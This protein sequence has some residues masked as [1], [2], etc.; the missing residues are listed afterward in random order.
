MVNDQRGCLHPVLHAFDVRRSN[1]IDYVLA[2]RILRGCM[3]GRIR[4]G[5]RLFSTATCLSCQ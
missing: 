5:M 3:P 4:A 2:R 1:I